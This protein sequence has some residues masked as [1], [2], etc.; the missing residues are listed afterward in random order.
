MLPLELVCCAVKTKA[1][2]PVVSQHRPAQ[3]CSMVRVAPLNKSVALLT[4]CTCC[5]VQCTRERQ[6]EKNG[7]PK[8]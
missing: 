4:S 8:A 3:A 6:W 2:H 1:A 5:V 7:A